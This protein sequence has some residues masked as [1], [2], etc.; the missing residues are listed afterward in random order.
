MRIALHL[1]FATVLLA[2]LGCGAAPQHP[3]PRQA[4]WVIPSLSL[5]DQYGKP[6][7]LRSTAH[8]HPWTVLFFYPRADTPG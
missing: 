5:P 4:G 2:L 8:Q 1:T 7:A 3:E 6:V